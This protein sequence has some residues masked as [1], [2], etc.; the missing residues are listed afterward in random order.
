[1]PTTD[2]PTPRARCFL[3]DIYIN[4]LGFLL[5]VI[6]FCTGKNWA[7]YARFLAEWRHCFGLWLG[8]G[9]CLR[10]YLWI[11]LLWCLLMQLVNTFTTLQCSGLASA[12]QPEHYFLFLL[13]HEFFHSWNAAILPDYF[14]PLCPFPFCKFIYIRR[15]L[16]SYFRYAESLS[17]LRAT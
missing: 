11:L 9:E 12:S 7:R 17:R 5:R 4:S 1:M 15:C 14:C 13:I 2:T 3:T 16:Y 10:V 8:Y 6:F